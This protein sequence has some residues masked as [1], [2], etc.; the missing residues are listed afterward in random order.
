MTAI[1]N[2]LL[3][4][5]VAYFVGSCGVSGDTSEASEASGTDEQALAAPIAEGNEVSSQALDVAS[6]ETSSE[7]GLAVNDEA[8]N[9]GHHNK[10]E[11]RCR[12]HCER[13]CDHDDDDDHD[14]Y[15][16]RDHDHD[17]HCE[18]R[19]RHYC[20]RWC[21]RHDHDDDHDHDD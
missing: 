6:P 1:K 15:N 9:H 10:C 4:V 20:E 16:N 8:E 5:G 2:V 19:C 18:D 17:H 21:D 13:D 12:R 3:A 11:R 7:T 14:D